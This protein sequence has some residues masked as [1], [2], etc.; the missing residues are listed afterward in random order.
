VYERN[1]VTNYD[2]FPG[3]KELLM[4]R[5]SP[6]RLQLAVIQNWP[7]LLSQRGVIH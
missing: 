4:I 6:V 2:V 1:D 5:A 3:S 7:E